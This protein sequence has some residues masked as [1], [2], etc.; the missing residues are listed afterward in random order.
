MYEMRSTAEAER[1]VK[2]AIKL[3]PENT[4]HHHA[5]GMVYRIEVER[6]FSEK[7][8]PLGRSAD[9]GVV[10]IRDLVEYWRSSASIY[11]AATARRVSMATSPRSR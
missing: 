6:I 4:V 5:L 2:L 3:E 9:E 8:I 10:A 1:C 11:P 7:L